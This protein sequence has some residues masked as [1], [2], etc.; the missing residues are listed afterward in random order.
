MVLPQVQGT[1]LEGG[2]GASGLQVSHSLIG[3]G[4][5]ISTLARRTF[6]SFLFQET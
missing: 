3:T 5:P 1:W 6:S 2:G 4:N